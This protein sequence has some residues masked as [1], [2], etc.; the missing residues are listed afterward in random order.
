MQVE[1][2]LLTFAVANRS[3]SEKSK[4]FTNK[5]HCYYGKK[6]NKKE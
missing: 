6:K 1:I 5:K 3:E 2:I 4:V